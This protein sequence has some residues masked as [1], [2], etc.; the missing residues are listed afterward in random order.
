MKWLRTAAL[1]MAIFG[2]AG[3]SW[4]S[5]LPFIDGDNSADLNEPAAL[6]DF[7][8]EIRLKRAWRHSVGEGLGRKYLRLSPAVVADRVIAADGYGVVIAYDRFSGKRVWRSQIG[9]LK[10]GLLDSLNFLDRR[11]PSFVSGGVGAGGGLVLLG[12]TLGEVV[13][14]EA[15]DG[16]ERWRQELGSE[17]LS[18]PTAARGLVFAQTIDGRLVAM[19]DNSGEIAWTFDSQVPI[20]TL[21]G[22]SS[23]VVEG[24]IVYTGFANGKVSALRAVNGEP[25]WEHRVMLPEGRSEL[26]RMVDVDGRPLISSGNVY[27]GAYQGRVKSLSRRDGRPLWEQEIST[28][29]D[30]A[31]G[32]GQVYVV[33]EDDVIQAIDQ[34]SGEINWTQESFK[35]RGLSSPIAF[36][37]YILVG[38]DEGYLHVLAQRDG[39]LLGRRKMDGDGLRSGMIVADGVVMVLGNSGSLQAIEIETI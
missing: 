16:S 29:L 21:R 2:L 13:A 36:S 7:D 14:L 28:Y 27:A 32:Y 9:E 25:V 4:F 20:L 5:W 23:P 22:T 31:E 3:C 35:N 18:I 34:Q 39:R 17:V 19:Q 10:G 30:L 37:N 6:V 24:D 12:T 26:E 15:S 11:D 8:A 38:D 33:D 1:G